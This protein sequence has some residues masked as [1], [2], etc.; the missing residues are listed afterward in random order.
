MLLPKWIRSIA[1]C[2][3]GEGA[4]E[5]DGKQ[6]KV[7]GGWFDG[8]ISGWS[9]IHNVKNAA[10]QWISIES[11]SWTKNRKFSVLCVCVFVDGIH[12]R[13]FFS[14]PAAAEKAR[15]FYSQRN[16]VVH[17]PLFIICCF[18]I[19]LLRVHFSSV[20][21]PA[22]HSMFMF[23]SACESFTAKFLTTS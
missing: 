16:F 17:G 4:S 3:K 21:S 9:G 15:K 6:Q 19:I 18:C 7:R 14:L 5:R 2:F 11:N 22:H 1:K 12:P 20:L 8:F 10:P 23:S 13:R